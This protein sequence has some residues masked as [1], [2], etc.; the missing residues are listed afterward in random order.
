[1]SYNFPTKVEALCPVDVSKF[2]YDSQICSLMFGSWSYNGLELDVRSMQSSADLSSTKENVEWIIDKVPIVRH[3]LYYGCCP[4]PYPDVTFY[5]H[6][7]RKPGYYVTNIIIPS[8][9]VTLVA[10]LGFLLPVD[11][12]EK[13]GLELT[14][15]L[16]MSVFQLLVADHL[17]PSAD[18]TPWIGKYPVLLPKPL[19]I[20][21]LHL[22]WIFGHELASAVLV[23]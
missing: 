14:V 18:S 17:P 5:I 15:M 8:I 19:L 23:L 9:L 10:S 4:E 6:L 1:M 12:G 7:T 16:A 13:V 2:P 3:E 20:K 22:K 11:S 21:P